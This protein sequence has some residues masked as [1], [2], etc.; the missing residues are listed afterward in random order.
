MSQ[1]NNIDNDKTYICPDCGVQIGG[2]NI[3]P[4][5]HKI[6]TEDK[7]IVINSNYPAKGP[8]RPLPLHLS[9]KTAYLVLAIIASIVC[10]AVC[11]LVPSPAL[12]CWFIVPV[13]FYGY[14]V[15]GN[16]IFSKTEIGA[17]IFMQGVCLVAL[18]YIYDAVF[19]TK[20]A[21]DYCLPIIISVMI[22]ICAICLIVLHKNNRTLFVSCNLISLF[23]IIPIILYACGVTNVLIPAV[24]AV[25]LGGLTLLCSL[26]FGL[27]KLRE[28]I[29]KV[30]H[31]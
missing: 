26:I 29:A 7:N 25:S 19:K 17:K 30:F 11:Y 13:L 28:Q 27:N 16:T 24:I 10:I 15:I 3:C 31:M 23:G 1:N 22:A 14:F 2:S 20:F 6:V 18:S 4:L 9:P 8:K 21:T 12:W 5:C